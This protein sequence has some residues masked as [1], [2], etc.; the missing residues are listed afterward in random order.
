MSCSKNCDK[1]TH[2][3]FQ[4]GRL[5]F[6]EPHGL[7][8]FVVKIVE[9]STARKLCWLFG[10]HKLRQRT[11]FCLNAKVGKERRAKPGS[12]GLRHDAM[13][14]RSIMAIGEL[15]NL[16]ARVNDETSCSWWDG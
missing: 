16:V 1:A 9:R 6:A 13:L 5:L 14:G 3:L 2:L 10:R 11:H 4:G 8:Q 7:E 15:G 12:R